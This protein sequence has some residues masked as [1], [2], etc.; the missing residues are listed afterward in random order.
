VVK[1]VTVNM[2]RVNVIPVKLALDVFCAAPRPNRTGLSERHAH[3]EGLMISS[4][5]GKVL[6]VNSIVTN[7]ISI[8]NVTT[9]EAQF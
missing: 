8:N 9:R 1:I 6:A 7:C 4:M 2:I 5:P 3:S